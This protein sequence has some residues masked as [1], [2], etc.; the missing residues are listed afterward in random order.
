MVDITLVGDFVEMDEDA[1]A[2]ADVLLHRCSARERAESINE[3]AKWRCFTCGSVR[4]VVGG[5]DAAA[6]LT[7]RKM[8][9]FNKKEG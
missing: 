6:W 3:K 2:L 1:A 5:R 4:D 8:T 7:D 9:E